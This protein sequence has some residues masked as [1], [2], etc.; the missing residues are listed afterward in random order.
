MKKIQLLLLFCLLLAACA[1]EK[2]E[3][4]VFVTNIE[5]PP[6]GTVFNPGDKVTVKAQGFQADD[7]IMLE[8]RWPLTD[9]PLFDEGY[10]LGV[11][12]LITER[13]ATSITFLAPGHYPA[14]TTEVFLRRTGIGDMM[15]LGKISV[16]DGQSPK[17][18]QLYGIVNSHSDTGHRN[19]IQHIDSQTGQATEITQLEDDRK[20][21]SCIVSSDG[22]W[23]LCGIQT[24]D[25]NR[26]IVIY[27]LCM[28]YWKNAGLGHT[29][30]LC[31][32]GSSTTS[33]VQVDQNH[34]T[35]STV[36]SWIN[37]RSPNLA[38]PTI[39][40]PEGMKPEALTYYP[41]IQI[42]GGLLLSANNG[43]GTFSPVVISLGNASPSMHAFDPIPATALIPFWTIKP[44]ENTHPT[45]YTRTGGFLVVRTDNPHTELCLWNMETMEMEE[46][47]ATFP[48]SARSITTHIPDVDTQE[49]YVLFEGRDSG[50]IIEVYDLNRKEWRSFPN[51][52]FAYSEIVMAR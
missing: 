48:N 34:V 12:G 50:R 52:G 17:D 37:T 30:T 35:L 6:A 29:L 25:G 21:F 19:C 42:A 16:A 41:G 26:N 51:F 33:I 13:T 10:A 43:D 22:N 24:Q 9:M 32:G 1:K 3:R 27:D 36:N 39:K 18:F 11:R 8:I 2:D 4:P 49:L 23:S 44:K 31:N 38:N 47:F 28:R 5:M 14:S 20:D 45:Q 7:E 15:S 40:L 46:P